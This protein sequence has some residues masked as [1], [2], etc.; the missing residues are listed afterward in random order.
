M[1]E[2]GDRD[3]VKDWLER[4]PVGK[5]NDLKPEKAMLLISVPGSMS[6]I[7]GGHMTEN[8]IAIQMYAKGYRYAWRVE[9]DDRYQFAK[10]TE[11][12]GPFMRETYPN[13]KVMCVYAVIETGFI[14]RLC[15]TCTVQDQCKGCEA[16]GLE[17]SIPMKA[18]IAEATRIISEMTPD[19]RKKLRAWVEQYGDHLPINIHAKE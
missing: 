14:A 3:R 10:S 8:E 17:Y 16:E 15:N 4:N 13:S 11:D 6:Q 1:T 18:K 19:E 12:I 7:T 9:G 5:E 2:I